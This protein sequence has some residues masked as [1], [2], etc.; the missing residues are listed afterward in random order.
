MWPFAKKAEPAQSGSPAP[1]TA[2]TTVVKTAATPALTGNAPAEKVPT[3]EQLLAEDAE[4]DKLAAEAG[5][6][7]AAPKTSGSK[8]PKK[9][10]K[11]AVKKAVK[12]SKPAAK[13]A[14]KKGKK[15]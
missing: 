11:K 8:K 12:K 15:K 10:K 7:A 4:L 2:S 14:K 5:I 9:A 1:G 6:K 13:K 3:T